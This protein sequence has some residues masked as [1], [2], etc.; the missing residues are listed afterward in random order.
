[1]Q[2]I[3]A[4]TVTKPRNNLQSLEPKCIYRP[5][6]TFQH[7]FFVIISSCQIVVLDL[8]LIFAQAD[9]TQE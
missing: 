9:I 8:L 3:R 1:M 7:S 4:Q 5:K 6:Q 2:R